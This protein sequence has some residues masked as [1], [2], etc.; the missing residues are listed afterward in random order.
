M[1][2]Q[3]LCIWTVLACL[4]WNVH[5]MILNDDQQKALSL[6]RKYLG[7]GDPGKVPRKQK[8]LFARHPRELMLSPEQADPL[9]D[10]TEAMARETIDVSA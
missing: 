10:A 7:P 8:A 1:K 9:T 6:A 2:G 3:L 5:L 4:S